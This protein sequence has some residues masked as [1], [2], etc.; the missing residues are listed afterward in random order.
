MN[1]K[2]EICKKNYDFSQFEILEKRDDL[3]HNKYYIS[4][5]ILFN[6]M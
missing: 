3:I 4:I 5:F 6:I 1:Q 2:K